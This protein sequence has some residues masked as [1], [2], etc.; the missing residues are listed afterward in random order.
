MID[1]Q[2]YK[3]TCIAFFK[4]LKRGRA[5]VYIG[6]NMLLGASVVGHQVI[7]DARHVPSLRSF[8]INDPVEASVMALMFHSV[9]AGMVCVD[10]DAGSGTYSIFLAS[11]AGTNG[12]VY[13]FES[14]PECYEMLLKNAQLN[15]VCCLQAVRQ[16][17]TNRSGL[18]QRTYF[19]NNYQFFFSQPE[20]LKS[21][22]TEVQCV[23]L[24]DYL[25]SAGELLIDFININNDEELPVIW[26]GMTM[27]LAL[28]RDVKILCRF[29]ADKMRQMGH[30]PEAFLQ[31]AAQKKFCCCLLPTLAEISP[32]QLLSHKVART[33]LFYRKT[34]PNK[35]N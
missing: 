9:K 32:D 24:D 11:L 2:K 10:I 3:H 18:L 19:D 27:T 35:V 7:C 25:E 4:S 26:Q 1:R 13:S 33:I 20:D 23:T 8:F 31:Q 30:D 5:A 17:V 29:N 12:K 21:R 14:L 16:T 15:D 34:A 6:N 22:Q 28:S